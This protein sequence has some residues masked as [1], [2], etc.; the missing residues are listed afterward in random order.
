MTRHRQ[1]RTRRSSPIR[2]FL[3]QH[4][5]C[6]LAAAIGGCIALLIIAAIVMPHVRGN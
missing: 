2:R 4:G 6:I 3:T 1:G 5:P